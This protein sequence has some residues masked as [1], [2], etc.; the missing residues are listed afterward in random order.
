[1]F[2]KFVGKGS[3]PLVGRVVV[4][5][6]KPA[7]VRNEEKLKSL[8]DRGYEFVILEDENW[9]D[10]KD[11]FNKSKNDTQESVEEVNEIEVIDEEP[12]DIHPYAELYEGHWTKQ[13]SK[14]KE[15][16]DNPKVI[17]EVYEYGLESG[18]SDG[19]LDRVKEYLNE[20][21]E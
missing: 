10:A 11:Y 18:A 2:V 12:E 8:I 7:K 9:L 21:E 6:T 19:V 20:L 3:P 14:I 1:M 15:F 13:V 16:S 17:E 4:P 5:K